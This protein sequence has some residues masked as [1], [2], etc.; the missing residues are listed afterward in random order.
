[1]TTDVHGLHADQGAFP[2]GEPRAFDTSVLFVDVR[3]STELLSHLEMHFGPLRAGDFF[4][5]F[6]SGCMEAI[7]GVTPAQC[8]R[9]GDGVLTTIEGPDRMRRAVDA[10]SAAIRFARDV[11]D[12]ENSELLAGV[13]RRGPWR[14]PRRHK[15]RF[16]VG[17]GIDQGVIT[18]S[19]ASSSR[20]KAPELMASYINVAVKLSGWA[21]PSNSIAITYQAFRDAKLD[22]TSAYRWKHRIMKLGGRYRHIVITRPPR[23]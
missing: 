5:R 18:E 15:V 1:M 4:N 19:L 6:L 2:H 11:F 13:P 3:R 10:A 16:A 20:G 12:P 14:A 8:E 21:R 23:M 17:A 9:S 22:G 7:V